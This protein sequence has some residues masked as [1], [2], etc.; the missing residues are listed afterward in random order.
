MTFSFQL[1]SD[2]TETARW[3]VRKKK[4]G[5]HWKSKKGREDDGGEGERMKLG[6]G[7]RL[8]FSCNNNSIREKCMWN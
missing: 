6:G 4:R 1:S 3:T 8:L 5:R 7:C 2:E